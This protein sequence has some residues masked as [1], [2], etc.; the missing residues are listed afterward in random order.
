MDHNDTTQLNEP[1]LF[2]ELINSDVNCEEYKKI[3]NVYAAYS[4]ENGEIIIDD[5]VFLDDNLFEHQN[6]NLDKIKIVRPNYIVKDG[7]R[8]SL[9]IDGREMFF[10]NPMCGAGISGY[11]IMRYSKAEQYSI[12]KKR[13]LEY[14][15]YI[16]YSLVLANRNGEKGYWD[17]S[18]WLVSDYGL[19][20]GKRF[21]NICGI[22]ESYRIKC[23]YMLNQNDLVK[24]IRMCKNV[25]E[26][27][28]IAI[29]N[30][31][32]DMHNQFGLT[33][34]DE[35][36][37]NQ[38]KPYGIK[39]DCLIPISLSNVLICC[40]AFGASQI[41]ISSARIVKTIS[42]IGWA[43]GQAIRLCL[44]RN[45]NDTSLDDSLISILQS[46][47]YTNFVKYYSIIK[48]K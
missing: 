27:H 12:L 29:G 44:D 5:D 38:L 42:Q 39:Y 41:A 2:F 22:R 24:D 36:N 28:F 9:N 35:F 8:Y 37:Q 13:T 14:W 6:Y 10:C 4:E 34:I 11:E 48:E 23:R 15:K 46:E 20:I 16:K 3:T 47:R 26:S 17:K 21:A 30:H 32:V 18:G 40:K 43:G 19:N 1:S 25:V 7:Y 45:L 33:G 31:N